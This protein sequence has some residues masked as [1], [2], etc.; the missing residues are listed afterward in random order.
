MIRP[1][2]VEARDGF[3]LW[4]KYSDGVTGEVDLSHLAGKGVFEEWSNPENFKKVFIAD[5][6]VIAWTEEVELCP[7]AIYMELTGKSLVGLANDHDVMNKVNCKK[8]LDE[9]LWSQVHEAFS[10]HFPLLA[11]TK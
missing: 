2:E 11:Q 6:R 4:L 5:H 10:S 3:R 8:Q 9:Q 1:A 7:D